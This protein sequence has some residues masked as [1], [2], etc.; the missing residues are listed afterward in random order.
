MNAIRESVLAKLQE[1]FDK[2]S[3]PFTADELQELEDKN[4]VLPDNW[5][6]SHFLNFPAI[7]EKSIYNATIQ[8][9][10]IKCIPRDWDSREF[11]FIYKVKYIKIK[12][13]CGYNSNANDVMGKIKYGL[14]KPENI[15][16][17]KST[18]LY[19]EKWEDILLKNSK[20]MEALTLSAP[21]DGTSIFK[22]GK[23][24]KNN[25]NYFQMQTRSADEPMTTFVTCLNCNNRWKC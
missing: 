18:D 17:M 4:I 3:E 25:C 14:W 5:I 6:S 12:C 13:N 10:R 9:A 19:P 7:I 22:C 23:C 11:K 24:K 15:I 16:T 1:L 2:Q 8:E 21:K 20:K